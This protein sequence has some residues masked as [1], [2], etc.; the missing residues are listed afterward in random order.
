MLVLSS[1]EKGPNFMTA[2]RMDR[3]DGTALAWEKLEGRGPTI[4]FLPGFRSDMTGDKA[5]GLATFAAARGQ[6]ILRFDYSGHGASDGD[7]LDGTIGVWAADALAAIDRLTTGNLVLVGSSMGGWI[8]LLTAIVRP[9]RVRA[10]V[11][12]AA[13]PDFTQRLMW[14]SM[15]P[16]ERLKLIQDGVLHIPSQYG[17][18]TPI[19]RRL[20]DDGRNHLVLEHP[21]PFTG[22]VRLLHGQADPDVPWEFSLRIAER[23]VSEDVRIA[24]VKDGDHRLSRPRDLALLYR[25]VGAL[26]DEDGA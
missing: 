12:I 4:V 14:D 5:T 18:P 15:A 2:G 25:T 6:A 10:L 19:T 8:A 9:D 26:L 16:A 22:Q 3:G 17:D 11:G 20:I 24:L 13:A 23:V 7:F 21:I 1:G